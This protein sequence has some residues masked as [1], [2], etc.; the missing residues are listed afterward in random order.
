MTRVAFNVIMAL[1]WAFTAVSRAI[2]SRR[3]ASTCPSAVFG[4]ATADH[5]PPPGAREEPP[6]PRP[7][8]GLEVEWSKVNSVEGQSW[9]GATGVIHLTVSAAPDSPPLVDLIVQ[10]EHAVKS[11]VGNPGGLLDCRILAMPYEVRDINREAKWRRLAMYEGPG[12]D[13]GASHDAWRC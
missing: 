10:A 4:M 2:L 8:F 6:V 11:R 13:I 3:N 5:R 12:G 9:T 7:R 1:V